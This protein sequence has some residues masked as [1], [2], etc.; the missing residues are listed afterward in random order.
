MLAMSKYGEIGFARSVASSMPDRY[1]K[2]FMFM[3]IARESRL[4]EDYAAVDDAFREVRQEDV[5]VQSVEDALNDL[6]NQMMER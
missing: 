4:R 5:G 2:A 1:L 3:R 6:R